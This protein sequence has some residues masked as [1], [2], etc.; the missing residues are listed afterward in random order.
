MTSQSLSIPFG[1]TSQYERHWKYSSIGLDLSSLLSTLEFFIKS[2]PQLLKSK[3]GE[4]NIK[5]NEQN[6]LNKLKDFNFEIYY[7][8]LNF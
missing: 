3:I 4:L 7:F 6:L 8:R 5:R 1:W 2:F